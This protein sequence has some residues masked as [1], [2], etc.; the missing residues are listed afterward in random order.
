MKRDQ[1]QFEQWIEEHQAAQYRHALW[2][3]GRSD[4]AH[5]CVQETYYQAWRDRKALKDGNKVLGWLLTILKRMVYREYGQRS[6]YAKFM[7][8]QFVDVAD[9]TDINGVGDMMDLINA[10]RTLSAMHREVILLYG[11]HGLSYQEISTV[12][13]IPTGT[14]MSRISRA[15]CALEKAMSPGKGNSGQAADISFLPTGHKRNE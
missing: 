9:H 15:R 10:M 13:D 5:D 6:Q 3:T 11:L 2:M 4:V 14:V 1:R 7:S 8:E 12:L